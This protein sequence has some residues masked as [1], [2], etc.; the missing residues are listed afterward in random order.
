[1]SWT[2]YMLYLGSINSDEDEGTELVKKRVEASSF[3][4]PS[5][6]AEVC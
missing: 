1:M 4:K 3:F 2:N 5:R 6:G